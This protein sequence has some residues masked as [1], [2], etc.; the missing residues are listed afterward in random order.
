MARALALW[1]GCAALLAC[2]RN[3]EPYVP[4][5]E[6]REPDLSKIFPEGAERV[7]DTAPM[8]MPPPPGEGPRGADPFAD[9]DPIR[10]VVLVPEELQGRAV[11][12][13]CSVCHP[14]DPS[15]PV[16]DILAAFVDDPDD[17]NTFHADVPRNFQTGVANGLTW[18]TAFSDLQ[19]AC[20]AAAAWGGDIT[21]IRVADGTYRP[22]RSTGNRQ[23][24]FRCCK[25]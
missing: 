16:G 9:V 10:G 15:D 4:G 19:D 20:V 17:D 22:D 18:P 13:S 23:H 2:D 25:A 11:S 3:V 6:P 14:T 21:E 7:A 12:N 24:S 5:E 1:L 8:E